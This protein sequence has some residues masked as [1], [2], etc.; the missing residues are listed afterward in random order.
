MEKVQ[1]IAPNTVQECV[2]RERERE[3]ENMNQKRK[4]KHLN[5]SSINKK[6][7]KLKINCTKAP[8]FN[9]VTIK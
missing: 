7:F 4:E 9:R 6:L 1:C 8:I 2:H 5:S 3:R